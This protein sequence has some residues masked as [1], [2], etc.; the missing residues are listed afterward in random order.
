MPHCLLDFLNLSTKSP[1]FSLIKELPAKLENVIYIRSQLFKTSCYQSKI[2]GTSCFTVLRIWSTL[3]NSCYLSADRQRV[4]HRAVRSLWVK[5]QHGWDEMWLAGLLHITTIPYQC[6]CQY[7]YLVSL[8]TPHS[9]HSNV[10]DV[11]HITTIPHQCECQ[12]HYLVSLPTPHSTHSN[13]S[14]VIHITTI[15]YQCECQYH[16]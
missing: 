14:T 10:S 8:P 6:E 11:I 2:E 1:A 13:V 12:Y 3:I 9:T 4:N 16:Y 7:H 15:P 5:V